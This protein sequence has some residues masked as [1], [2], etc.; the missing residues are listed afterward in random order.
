MFPLKINSSRIENNMCTKIIG[1]LLF[2]FSGAQL[3]KSYSLADVFQSKRFADYK[4][5]KQINVNIGQLVLSDD[6]YSLYLLLM[7]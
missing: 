2:F 6:V 1:L 4:S 5:R 3:M 7:S